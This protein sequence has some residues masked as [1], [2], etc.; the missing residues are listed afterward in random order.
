MKFALIDS[1]N[2]LDDPRFD[3]D[4]QQ[5]INNAIANGVEHQIVCATEFA[6]WTR[7]QTVCQNSPTLH[8]CYG[9][10]PY[11]IHRHKNN[12]LSNLKNWLTE[13]KPVAVGECGLDLYIANPNFDHQLYFFNEQLRLARDFDLPVVIHARKAVDPVIKQLRQFPGLTGMVHSFAGSHQQADQ[14]IKLDM[15]ISLGGPVTYP[16]ANKLRSI[17]ATLPLERLLIETDAPD[18]PGNLHRGERNQPANLTEIVQVLAELR[19]V[20]QYTIAQATRANAI[21]LFNLCTSTVEV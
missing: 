15:M 18:Q 3:L 13:Q 19:D 20:D 4:R 8:P 2:H 14:L 9:L 17:A 1:H 10:H 16:R 6:T 5:I 11:F 7:T 21:K 12:D